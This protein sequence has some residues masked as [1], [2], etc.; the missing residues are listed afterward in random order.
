MNTTTNVANPVVSPVPPTVWE[1][2]QQFPRPVWCLLAGMF[3]NRFGTFV[4]PFLAL[5]VAG[6]GYSAVVG[7][8]VLGAFGAGHFLASALGGHLADTVGPRRTIVASMVCG[9]GTMLLLSQARSLEALIVLAFLNGL[10]GEFYRPAS[11][12]LLANLVSE[13]QRVTAYA[14]YRFAINA[15]FAVGPAL[16]GLLAGKSYLWLF[17]GDALTSAAYGWVAL[18]LLPRDVLAVSPSVRR[19]L[20]AGYSLREALTMAWRDVRFR[21]LVIATFAVALVFM[22]MFTTLSMPVAL[23]YAASL[24]PAA[25]RGRVLGLYGLTW[26][27]AMAVGPACG[28]AVFALSPPALWLGC[29]ALGFAAAAVIRPPLRPSPRVKP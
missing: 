2:V 3:I 13:D 15:G 16:G 8:W 24:G 4:L 12:A 28:S 19:V 22:Q 27:A 29:A 14:A 11:S 10:A 6:L 9:A 25:M 18:F 5:H 23:A 17:V 20:R 26:A 21:R 1:T 7:G